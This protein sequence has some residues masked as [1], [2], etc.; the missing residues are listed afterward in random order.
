M[1]VMKA[2][3]AMKAM[4]ATKKKLAAASASASAS[5]GPILKEYGTM[6]GELGDDRSSMTR[7]DKVALLDA[8][9]RAC[10]QRVRW[11]GHLVQPARDA[12]PLQP[13]GRHG[14]SCG[15]SASAGD[16]I[17]HVAERSGREQGDG[18]ASDGARMVQGRGIRVIVVRTCANNY[19]SRWCWYAYSLYIHLYIYIYIYVYI[20]TD[21]SYKM[22]RN[23]RNPKFIEY[24]NVCETSEQKVKKSQSMAEHGDAWLQQAPKGGAL[25]A[26]GAETRYL[27]PIIQQ[28]CVESYSGF[29][30][31]EHRTMAG[32]FCPKCML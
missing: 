11:Q 16:A 12:P 5:K 15:P 18:Q 25:L 29:D 27:A 6:E 24:L 2:V 28:L 13:M 20:H 7:A 32:H 19:E 8:K 4:S 10:V 30:G 9:V 21:G 3:K 23:P 31:D 17:G 14:A 22:R 1:V 26:K